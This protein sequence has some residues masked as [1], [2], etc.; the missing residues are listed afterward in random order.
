MSALIERL[1]AA[2]GA[3]YDVERELAA[4]G[5]GV[6]FLGRERALD[7]AVAIKVLRPEQATAVAAERF[8][9]E[10]RL[11]AAVSHS[12]VVTIHRVGEAGGLFYLVM[13]RLEGTLA[14][15]L[16]R[17][18]LPASDVV[19]IAREVL[20]G[21]ARVHD[22]GIVHRDIKPSNIFLRDDGRAVLGDFGIARSLA[23]GDGALTATGFSP[24]T[25]AYMAPEQFASADVGP[26]ADLY[27]LGMV[28]YEAMTGRRWAGMDP[29]VGDWRGIP[30]RPRRSRARASGS[31]ATSTSDS[32]AAGGIRLA[33]A[34]CSST[35]AR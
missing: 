19:R 33:T 12:N 26:V 22:R 14:E 23:S 4:G 11:L 2:L 6:V 31:P 25:P 1:R 30:S 35:N 24:G 27:A 7:R 10:A 20:D 13:E 29:V 3:E 16:A 9:R 8:Q 34:R 18:L 17:G 5:M 28:C 21:L 15:R 32:P